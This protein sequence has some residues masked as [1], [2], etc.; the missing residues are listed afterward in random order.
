MHTMSVFLVGTHLI[1]VL[2]TGEPLVGLWTSVH[3]NFISYRKLSPQLFIGVQLED[4]IDENG[5]SS[6]PCTEA[7]RQTFAR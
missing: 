1:G 2:F 7:L 6:R 3:G 4:K 5:S